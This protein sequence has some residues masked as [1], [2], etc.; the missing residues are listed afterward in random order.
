MMLRQMASPSPVP[1]FLLESVDSTCWKRSK[2]LSSLSTG[3]PRPRSI[4]FSDQRVGVGVD[5][6]RDRRA[7]GENLIAFR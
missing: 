2:M 1:P 4:T 3:M 5:H 7:S 6:D